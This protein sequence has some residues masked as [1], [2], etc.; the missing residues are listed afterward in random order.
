MNENCYYLKDCKATCNLGPDTEGLDSRLWLT[1]KKPIVL[2]ANA[3]YTIYKSV[4]ILKVPVCA[5]NS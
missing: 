3:Y 4:N 5:S 2:R 1:T